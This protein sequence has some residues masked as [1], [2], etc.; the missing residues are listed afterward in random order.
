[1]VCFTAS[2]VATVLAMTPSTLAGP[3]SRA[4]K[5]K[6]EDFV[7]HD[8]S[9]R[10]MSSS[11][12]EPAPKISTYKAEDL[13][14]FVGNLTTSTLP[15]RKSRDSRSKRYIIGAD[16]RELW[17]GEETV[18]PGAAV[19]RIT[20]DDGSICSGALV[21]PRHVLTSK[22]C[23][24]QSPWGQ[25]APGYDQGSDKYGASSW[26]N[27]IMASIE[28]DSCLWKNDFAL[29]ILNERLGDTVGYFGIKLPDA[30]KL[31]KPIFSHQGYPSDLNRA[32]RPYRQTGV[33]VHSEGSLQCDATGHI[34]TDVDAMPGQAG[35]PL[36][37]MDGQG[38]YEIWGVLAG[39]LKTDE[40]YV[41]GF[42][43]GDVMVSGVQMVLEQYP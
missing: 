8:K 18:F 39:G 32:E 11:H 16:D 34:R 37:E 14:A 24:P 42:A 10:L 2:L 7:V 25:F 38:N 31:D 20:F 23:I 12:T 22:S 6:F 9:V 41:T 33:T 17:E 21:G 15:G 30:E 4:Q 19:G 13:A 28:P 29:I 26:G 36:W 3:L 43:S 27:I 1:M 40:G 5:V 35:G